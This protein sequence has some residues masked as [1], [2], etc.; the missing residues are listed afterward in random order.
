MPGQT[1]ISVEKQVFCAGLYSF[2]I[3]GLLLLQN[4]GG[5]FLELVPLFLIFFAG[6]AFSSFGGKISD[7]SWVQFIVLLFYSGFHAAF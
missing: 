1:H 2:C 4:Y 5:N 3:G 6:L 7:N